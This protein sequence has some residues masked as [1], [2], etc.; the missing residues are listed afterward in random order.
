MNS[1]QALS[2]FLFLIVVTSCSSPQ[3]LQET[4]QVNLQPRQMIVIDPGHGGKDFGAQ[5]SAI[6]QYQEKS[7]NLTTALMLSHYLQRMGYQTILT[8]GE[9]IYV[10]LELRAAF[11]NS[12][13][14][15]L[16]VSIHYNS[17]PNPKAEGIEVFYY[18]SK[19][20]PERSQESKQFAATVLQQVIANTGAPS[21]G[22]KHGNL[23]VIRETKMPAILVEGGFMTNNHEFGKLKDVRY[24]QTIAESV[25]CGIHDYLHD[26]Q[27]K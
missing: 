23:A 11:A 16:F 18:D 12:N 15:A 7:L 2:Y 1:S 5:S 19:K 8:R 25:A 6:H 27:R 17:A 22:V 3:R 13:Y 21:R 9:D 26:L 20:D 4:T 10:P 14:G 24:L